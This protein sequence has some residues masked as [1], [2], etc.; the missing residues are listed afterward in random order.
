MGLEEPVPGLELSFLTCASQ[1]PHG[2]PF[3][4]AGHM[5]VPSRSS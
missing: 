5:E 2:A 4:R 1:V 3:L